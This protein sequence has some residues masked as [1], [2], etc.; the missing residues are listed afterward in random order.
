MT[1]WERAKEKEE[2]SRSARMFKPLRGFMASRFT[3]AKFMDDNDST[4]MPVDDSVSNIHCR[5]VHDC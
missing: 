3:A 5:F 1:E 2:F 4:E